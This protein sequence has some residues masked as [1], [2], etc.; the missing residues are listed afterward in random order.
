MG[1]YI[2][3]S[4]RGRDASRRKA[5]AL[6]GPPSEDLWCR[7]K[8][9]AFYVACVWVSIGSIVVPF[10]GLPFR[11]VNINHKEELLWSLWVSVNYVPND[12]WTRVDG[13][14]SLGSRARASIYFYPTGSW[15]L[16]SGDTFPNHNN[17]F[18]I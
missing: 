7:L 9:V 4:G 11:I 1:L 16:V 15:V 6:P 14:R 2:I 5:G 17:N 3:Q 12:V 18:L 8:N 13:F 10:W